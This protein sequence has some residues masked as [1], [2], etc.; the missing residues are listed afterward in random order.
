MN[1]KNKCCFDLIFTAVTKNIRIFFPDLE[2][3]LVEDI[4]LIKFC[5]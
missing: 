2:E 4:R 1:E 5:F 3:D